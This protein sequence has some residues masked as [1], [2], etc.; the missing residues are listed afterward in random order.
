MKLLQAAEDWE[1][2]ARI[3]V[4]E[5]GNL[6]EQGRI[7]TLEGWIRGVPEKVRH[8]TPWLS[9]WLASSRM[10]FNPAEAYG[11]FEQVFGEFR[12]QGDRVGVLLSWCG[13]IRTVLFQWTNMGRLTSGWTYFRTSILQGRLI[14]RL[15]WKPTWRTVWPASLCKCILTGLTRELG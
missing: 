14:P 3:I 5:A 15:R 9:Y 7:Q 12:S 10:S 1:S 4:A 11:L 6:I 13:M 8:E 2:L